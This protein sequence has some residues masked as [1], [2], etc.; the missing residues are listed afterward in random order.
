MKRHL[1]EIAN[2]L[3]LD[4]H[5]GDDG[6]PHQLELLRQRGGP[7]SVGEL[8]ADGRPRIEDFW[9]ELLGLAIAALAHVGGQSEGLAQHV[10]AEREGVHPASQ[11]RCSRVSR[12]IG[13]VLH[14]Q[15]VIDLPAHVDDQDHQDR[16]H[17]D[18]KHGERRDRA[19]LIA[20][21]AM[22]KIEQMLKCSSHHVHRPGKAYVG[23]TSGFTDLRP[24]HMIVAAAV[25]CVV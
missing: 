6:L 14:S 24:S 1:A 9:N 17:E 16:E 3:T 12:R 21:Q 11:Y 5:L 23:W 20:V 19:A 25:I 4:G 2:H 7:G 18:R 22:G 15:F 13:R 10:V 8:I